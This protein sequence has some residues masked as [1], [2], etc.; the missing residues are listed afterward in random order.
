MSV[1]YYRPREWNFPTFLVLFSGSQDIGNL[2]AIY[3]TAQLIVLCKERCCL[4][5]GL[6]LSGEHTIGT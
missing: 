3:Q 4:V 1:H 5:E 6:V 2:V